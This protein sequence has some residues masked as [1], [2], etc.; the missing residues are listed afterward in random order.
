MFYKPSLN[1]FKW[2]YLI[3]QILMLVCMK[4]N[5]NK[6]LITVFIRNI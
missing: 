5:C 2:D 6:L 4:L 1:K 3:N